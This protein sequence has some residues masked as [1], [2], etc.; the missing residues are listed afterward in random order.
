MSTTYSITEKPV[1]AQ[2]FTHLEEDNLTDDQ[3]R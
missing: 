1:V 3:I 2:N